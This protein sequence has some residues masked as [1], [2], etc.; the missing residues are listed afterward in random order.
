MLVCCFSHCFIL[1]SFIVC[2]VNRPNNY[3]VTVRCDDLCPF[4]ISIPPPVRPSQQSVTFGASAMSTHHHHQRHHN[5]NPVSSITL[6]HAPFTTT[7]PPQTTG[8]VDHNHADDQAADNGVPTIVHHHH[9][10]HNNRHSI[11]FAPAAIAQPNTQ[12]SS[13]QNCPNTDDTNDT[14]NIGVHI[15]HHNTDHTHSPS[16]GAQHRTEPHAQ[17]TTTIAIASRRTG[18]AHD[19][20]AGHLAGVQQ[21]CG[22]RVGR[23]RRSLV[24]AERSNATGARIAD[25][26][27]CT[28]AASAVAA[29]AP[30]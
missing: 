22:H 20:H 28:A 1:H 3:Q 26:C 4:L 12:F 19:E 15:G 13:P 7:T 2:V 8:H 25:H 24:I 23:L 11:E 16:I 10:H 17:S 6:A 14:V 18:D 9:H 27:R 29:H 5:K 21:R 30:L